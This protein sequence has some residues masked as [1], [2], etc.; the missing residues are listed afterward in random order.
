MSVLAEVQK[1]VPPTSTTTWSTS[2]RIGTVV[3]SVAGDPDAARLV[4][5]SSVAGRVSLTRRAWRGGVIVAGVPD[6]ARF[7]DTFRRD[8]FLAGVEEC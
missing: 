2:R 1:R 5:V 6:A 4:V 3:S 8:A 7:R